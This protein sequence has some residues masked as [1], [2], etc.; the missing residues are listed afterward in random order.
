M[1]IR[2]DFNALISW[3]GERNQKFNHPYRQ[4]ILFMSEFINIQCDSDGYIAII[5]PKKE[6]EKT[7]LKDLLTEEDFIRH[8]QTRTNNKHKLNDMTESDSKRLCQS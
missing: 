1:M 8:C 4:T 5:Q 3:K 2:L 7:I 6:E